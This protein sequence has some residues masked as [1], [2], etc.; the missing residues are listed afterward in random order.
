MTRTVYTA[1]FKVDAL[2]IALET[3]LGCK[4]V[5]EALAF[6]PFVI[7][8]ATR[9]LQLYGLGRG[10]VLTFGTGAY[11]Y[12]NKLIG[13]DSEDTVPNRDK[14]WRHSGAMSRWHPNAAI[15]RPRS[16]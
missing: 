15:A 1:T 8:L 10:S 12:G 9:F 7:V 2:D 4:C 6:S 11:W 14:M 13:L 3:A 5:L 16:V